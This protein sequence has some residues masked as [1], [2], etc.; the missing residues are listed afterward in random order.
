MPILVRTSTYRWLSSLSIF[1]L[2]PL[3]CPAPELS[4]VPFDI[5]NYLR[6]G[7]LIAKL[8]RKFV[9]P[10]GEFYHDLLRVRKIATIK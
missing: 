7:Y 4:Q 10:Y 1:T 5:E 9:Q 8:L 6:N 3:P 2:E